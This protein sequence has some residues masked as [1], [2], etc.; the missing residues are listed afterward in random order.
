MGLTLAGPLMFSSEVL[1]TYPGGRSIYRL[2]QPVLTH[3]LR[4]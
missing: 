4:L 3:H 1:L 2:T